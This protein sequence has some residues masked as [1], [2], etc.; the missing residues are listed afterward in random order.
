MSK[1]PKRLWNWKASEPSSNEVVEGDQEVTKIEALPPLPEDQEKYYRLQLQKL[2][3]PTPPDV[4]LELIAMYAFEWLIVG[5]MIDVED[6]PSKWCISCVQAIDEEKD[7]VFVHFIGWAPKWDTW[8]SRDSPRIAPFC[9]KTTPIILPT[10]AI[11]SPESMM[12]R[13]NYAELVG[14]LE[15]LGLP[16][17]RGEVL[18]AAYGFDLKENAI[19]AFLYWKT[20]GKDGLPG[21]VRKFFE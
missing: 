8:I 18:I 5:S 2:L 9:S 13:F 12:H 11:F 15:E 19:N 6:M 1:F 16:R 21:S 17:D 7:M 14:Y 3:D 10:G 20:F 4:I